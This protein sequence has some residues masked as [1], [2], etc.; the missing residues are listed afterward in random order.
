MKWDQII[1]HKDNIDLLKGMLSSFRIPHALLFTGPK[2]I[3]KMLSAQIFAAGIL[4]TAKE[5]KPCGT[6]AS[7]LSYNR[8]QHP[9]ARE[10]RPDEEGVSLTI[11]IDQIRALKRFA[12]LSPVL[13]EGRVCVIEDAQNMTVEAS[14]SLLK[15][16][17]E[18]PQNFYFILVASSGQPLLPTI[19]SRCQKLSF[20]PLP[21]DTLAGRLR[22]IGATDPA[23]ARAAASLSGGRM[24]K[25]IQ[26]L[27]PEGF[28]LRDQAAEYLEL[29]SDGTIDTPEEL[30]N[31]LAALDRQ[32][33]L[34]FLE[35]AGT[36][37]R[38][39]LFLII[40]NKNGAK[41]D[42]SMLN[43]LFN[44]DLTGRLRNLGLY[45]TEESLLATH[46]SL[47]AA[48]RA[49]SGNANARL[50]IDALTIKLKSLVVY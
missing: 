19:I 36:L 35:Y 30:L 4:C 32:N 48:V 28:A 23:K 9:D 18:P 27:K 39:M 8:R 50:T 31:R 12:L 46:K 49:I 44:P 16:L 38:D 21:P 7:C 5:E 26:L 43:A 15:L 37:V 45:W 1:G 6:C 40:N 42:A 3:G 29:L 10:V 41:Q 14:N 20:F 22:E 25:A 13:T 11:K 24:G 34:M 17:E 47:R 2:G 33:M